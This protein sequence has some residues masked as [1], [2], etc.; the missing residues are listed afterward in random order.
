MVQAADIQYKGIYIDYV[1]GELQISR[2]YIFVDANGNPLKR[3]ILKKKVVWEFV[4]QP[5]K[6]AL[7]VLD[8]HTK[9]EIQ[10]QENI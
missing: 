6:D 10:T 3:G 2:E 5:I 7:Q 1:N 9:T 8:N 4:P